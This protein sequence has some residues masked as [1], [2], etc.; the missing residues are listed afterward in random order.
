MKD[1]LL[2]LAGIPFGVA[3]NYIYQY[4]KSKTDRMYDPIKMIGN[5]GELVDDSGERRCSMG[6]I[7]YDRRRKMWTFD[8]TNYHN[9]GRPFC[10][11]TTE[12]SY[13][14]KSA[15]E[16]YYIFTNTLVESG[17]KGYMGF[18]VVRFR[19]QE[20]AWVPDHGFFVSGNEGETYRSHTMVPLD[21][22]PTN[23]SEVRKLFLSKLNLT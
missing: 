20:R 9:D 19:R 3:A 16:F 2:L 15:R 6:E 14:D 13:M 21:G 18:G 10:H 11:W 8:G 5:W 23:Q 7:R 4:V 22:I 17:Q 1:L 12:A